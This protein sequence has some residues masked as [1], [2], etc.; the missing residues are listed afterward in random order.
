MGPSL[1]ACNEN[2]AYVMPHV[3]A[4]A[5]TSCAHHM[6]HAHRQA[7]RPCVN[8]VCQK[9]LMHMPFMPAELYLSKLT[10]AHFST[11]HMKI[12]NQN[13]LK[14]ILIAMH[15][16]NKADCNENFRICAEESI[17]PLYKW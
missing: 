8:M 6:V 14:T 16:G 17:G 1:F 4:C 10:A 12:A 13:M 15:I 9:L 7:S 5:V 3:T 11:L 2:S